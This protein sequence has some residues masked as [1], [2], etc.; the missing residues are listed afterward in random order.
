[1][2]MMMNKFK[3]VC[4]SG[5]SAVLA[6]FM[7]V[8]VAV[9][10]MQGIDVSDWQPAYVTQTTEY[11]FALI[12]AT[13]G[14][15][16]SNVNFDAQVANVLNRG[17]GLGLYHFA[18]GGSVQAEADAFLNRARPYIGRAVLALDWESCLAYGG[19]GCV[20][21]NP[22]WGNG[23]W[24]RRFVRYIHT[25]TGVWPLVYVQA[26]AVNQVPSDV[27]ANCGLWVAQYATNNPTGYQT[28][29]W[30][31]G[32]YG[33]AVRQ[34]SSTG[35]LNGYNG[36]LDLNIFRGNRDQWDKY[37]NP[38]KASKSSGNTAKPS[39]SS[40]SQ[41][42]NWEALAIAVIRGDYGNGNARRT[43][44][45][46]AYGSGAYERVQ[47]IVNKRLGTTNSMASAATGARSV[48]VKSG[49]TISGIAARTGLYPLTAWRVP[50]GDLNR[51]YPGQAVT[52]IGGG[53]VVATNVA[54]AGRTVVVQRGETL[55]GIALRLGIDWRTIRG[56]CSGNPNVIYPGEM[57]TY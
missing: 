35:R 3:R 23:D 27:R 1:M 45:N 39:V 15:G 54:S 21:D 11:D 40:L 37:A 14:T 51:I 52:Y 55:T 8:G 53:V 43:N 48:V 36:D 19:G 33:E 9:A 13:Q 49:D 6:C 26:S 5:V 22:Q 50:S 41:G 47:S 18:N 7:C 12:K 28:A 56:Y 31:I 20:Q 2:I 25:K 30:R 4:I 34:Y 32:L 44:V 38:G 16:N 42:V 29:P 17:K 57:L 10:D 24:I 46:N